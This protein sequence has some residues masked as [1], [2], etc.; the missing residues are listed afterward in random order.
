MLQFDLQLS[1]GYAGSSGTKRCC[2]RSAVICVLPKATWHE[3]KSDLQMATT[4]VEVEGAQERPSCV[5][6]LAAANAAPGAT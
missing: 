3:L 5:P 6:R 4:F 1:T 2:T